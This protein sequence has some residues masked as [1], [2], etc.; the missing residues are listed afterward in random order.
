MGKV[1]SCFAKSER[2]NSRPPPTPNLVAVSSIQ[3]LVYDPKLRNSLPFPGLKSRLASAIVLS[4]HGIRRKVVKI[5]ITLNK[6]SRAYMLSQDCLPG[7][8]I[9]QYPSFESQIFSELYIQWNDE[10]EKRLFLNH[11][12]SSIG[13]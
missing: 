2:A 12:G 13:L 11:S 6:A 10:F 8:L 3:D 9:E 7:F 1:H 4:F 5:V